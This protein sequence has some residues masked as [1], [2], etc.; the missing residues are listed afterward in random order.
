MDSKCFLSLFATLV[1]LLCSRNV[2]GQSNIF[3]VTDYGAVSDGKTDNSKA[4]L[5][6]WKEAC[7]TNEGELY[8]PSGTYLL[9]GA[10][11]EGPC[12][13]NTYFHYMGTLKA[14][15]GSHT[16]H[17]YWISF[18]EID[19]LTISGQG[20][21]D[22]NGPSAW[23][24]I[25]KRQTSI[26]AIKVNNLN[27]IGISS[28]NSKMFHFHIVLC[29][30]VI[31]N[32]VN[33]RAPANSPNTDGI[34][35]SR[36]SNVSITNSRI[37][38]GDDCISMGDGIKNIN[39]ESIMCGPGHGIS[40]GSLGKYNDEEDVTG[41]N[42]RNCTLS[43][44]ANGLRIKTWAPSSVST[45]VS[46]VTFE[47]INIVNVKNPIIIDQFY[48][49]GSGCRHDKD[50][51]I[52]INGV[53]YINIKGASAAEVALNLQCSRSKPCQNIQFDGLDI[54]T[55]NGEPSTAV[56]SGIRPQ[57]LGNDDNPSSCVHSNIED[58]WLY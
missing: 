38:T 6:A 58:Y 56:C 37:S 43:N 14:S 18:Q 11:F 51:D 22:G 9:S 53:K 3:K 4:F 57:F 34:H 24:G 46:D 44:T 20:T 21:F 55:T 1:L 42:V 10:T 29:E 25:G 27:I 8:I 52:K 13:G 32:N 23:R 12:N 39:I 35:L 45:T 31:V 47:N 30:N 19:G 33:I 15:A 54:T 17:D 49:P 5:S 7:E 48:C 26:K 36:C 2:D 50:S 28:L 16:Q 40:I 41:V